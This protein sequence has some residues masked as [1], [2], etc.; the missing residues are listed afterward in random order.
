MANE[1]TRTTSIRVS[2]GESVESFGPFTERLTQAAIGIEGGIQIVGTSE[3]VLSVHADVTTL[4]VTAFKNLDTTNYVD[5]GPESGGAM[6]ALIRLK[7]GETASMRL[8]PGVVIRGQA[9]TSAVKLKKFIL[10]D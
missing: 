2:N 4:G 8:K 1:I 3:E 10:Q 9:N 5:I 7:A 6:V